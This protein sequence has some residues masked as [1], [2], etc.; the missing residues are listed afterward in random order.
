MRAK[1]IKVGHHFLRDHVE[2]GDI[3]MGYINTERQLTDIFI[4]LLDASHF[5]SLLGGGGLVFDIPMAWFEG[6]LYFTCIYSILSS[7]HCI[8]FIST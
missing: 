8:S 2:K 7:S 1:H 6:G 4:I 3:E 5:A